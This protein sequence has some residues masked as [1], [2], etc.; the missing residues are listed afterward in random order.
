MGEGTKTG[1]A[2]EAKVTIRP[3]A[4]PSQA[5]AALRCAMRSGLPKNLTAPAPQLHSQKEL[6]APAGTPAWPKEAEITVVAWPLVP[7]P[8]CRVAGAAPARS[9][10]RRYCYCRLLSVVTVERPQAGRVRPSA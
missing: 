9:G 4:G 2:C 8:Q 10:G 7:P 5:A 3:L 1:G 6:G